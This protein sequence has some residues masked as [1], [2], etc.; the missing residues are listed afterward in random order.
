MVMVDAIAFVVKPLL[1]SF[2]YL[3]NSLI[4]FLLLLILL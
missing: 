4:S 2:K 3:Y 1:S